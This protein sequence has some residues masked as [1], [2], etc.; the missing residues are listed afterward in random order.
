MVYL[1]LY[2]DDMLL[3]SKDLEEIKTVKELLASRFDMKDLGPARRILGMDIERDREG[4]VL[5][6]SQTGYVKKVLLA[7]T[8][9]KLNR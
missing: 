7:L 2:V 8:W 3:A 6:L 5:T 4:G 1:L 9:M